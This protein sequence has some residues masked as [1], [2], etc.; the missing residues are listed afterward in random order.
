MNVLMPRS[1]PETVEAIHDIVWRVAD[2]E[3]A[4]TS[5]LDRKAATL[6]T[7]ASLLTSLTATLGFRSVEAYPSGVSFALF[8]AALVGLGGSV[9]LAVIVLLPTE[10]TV[11][12]ASHLERLRPG[13]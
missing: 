3:T 10:F 1:N 13:P 4:R 7:F 12:G 9:V 6:A 11:L 2:V 8:G 5:A